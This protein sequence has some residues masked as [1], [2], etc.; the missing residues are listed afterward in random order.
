MGKY[1]D[2]QGNPMLSACITFIESI[3]MIDVEEI[4]SKIHGLIGDG[5]SKESMTFK[6]LK[7]FIL[8]VVVRL[9]QAS[10]DKRKRLRFIKDEKNENLLLW[11][12]SGNTVPRM[13][14]D[15]IDLIAK[16]S[17]ASSLKESLSELFD[18]EVN[19]ISG[20]WVFSVPNDDEDLK[21]YLLPEYSK[22]FN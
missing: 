20:G 10:M 1:L 8:S 17:S 15:V 21:I 4:D 16:R 9:I 18:F 5:T 12:L 22:F 3:T 14:N 2:R 13:F 19:E 7:F 6:D 11:G